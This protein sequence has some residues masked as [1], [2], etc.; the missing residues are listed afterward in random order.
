MT[1]DQAV[2]RP[3]PGPSVELVCE[4]CGQVIAGFEGVAPDL[5]LLFRAAT[6]HRHAP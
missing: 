1:P 4:Q 6:A 3:G 2:I 5:A